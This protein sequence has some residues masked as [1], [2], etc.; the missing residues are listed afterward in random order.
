[1]QTPLTEGPSLPALSELPL[2]LIDAINEEVEGGI[3]LPRET[4]VVALLFETEK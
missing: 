4:N 1:M 3:R 2:T